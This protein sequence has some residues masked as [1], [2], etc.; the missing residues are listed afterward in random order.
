M[1]QKTPVLEGVSI[2]KLW[3]IPSAFV[4]YCL[5]VFVPWVPRSWRPPC[6]NSWALALHD[7][8][9][10]S[11]EFGSDVVF[12]FGPY[13]F[14]YFGSTPHTYA[15]TIIGWAVMAV[16]YCVAVWKALNISELPSWTKLL[17]AVLVTGITTSVDVVDAQIYA[18]TVFASAAWILSNPK[19]FFSNTIVGF[20]LALASLVKFSWLLAIAP[21]VATITFL[22]LIYQSRCSLVGAIYAFSCITLWLAAGQTISSIGIYLSS[23]L[24]ITGGYAEAMQL[25]HPWGMNN[26]W[27][28]VSIAIFLLGLFAY[29][30]FPKKKLPASAFFCALALNLLI[31]FKAG[32]VRHDHHEVVSSALLVSIGIL[33]FCILRNRFLASIASLAALILYGLSIM[34][35]EENPSFESRF[36]K[37]YQL[38]GIWDFFNFLTGKVTPGQIYANDMDSIAKS[39]Q[40]NLPSGTTSVRL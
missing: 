17:G 33:L 21:C 28:Y 15:L 8:F 2:L 5:S 29:E 6:N 38:Q 31:G 20:S 18:F 12:T 25:D 27:A 19:D 35:N 39:H 23:S 11:A 14:L 3:M 22:G 37:T 26:V 10:K 4:F 32:Y 30:L 40:F 1:N 9:A 24:E 16:G 13:G 7:A 36:A 34:L